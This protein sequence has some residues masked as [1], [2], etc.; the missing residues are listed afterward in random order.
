ML[1]EE[2]GLASVDEAYG[3]VTKDVPLGRAATPDE[4]ANV[5]CFIASEEASMMNGSIVT[6]DGGST[7]VDL[8]TL[9]F[10]D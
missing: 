4:V 10:A 6:V 1:V 9:A 3:L 5:I 2:R 8:P 7:V